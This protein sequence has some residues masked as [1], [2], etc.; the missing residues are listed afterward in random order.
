MLEVLPC[1]SVSHNLFILLLFRNALY[2]CDNLVIH[3]TL[4]EHLVC[5]YIRAIRTVN[6][7]LCLVLH[8]NTISLGPVY[9]SRNKVTFPNAA[10]I[11]LFFS[12]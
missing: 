7:C 6:Y 1:S 4:D 10:L 9:S 2:S 12:Q 11:L 3:S 8:V 5:F